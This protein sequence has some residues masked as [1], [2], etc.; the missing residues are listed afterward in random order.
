MP[1]PVE[2]NDA[3]HGGGD[4]VRGRRQL[5]GGAC[6]ACWAAESTARPQAQNATNQRIVLLDR[7]SKP[8]PYFIDVP[9]L[10][11]YRGKCDS[12]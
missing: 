3:V 7:K 10:E 1:G 11:H 6:E 4:G 12:A 8:R 5:A 9:S 2:L